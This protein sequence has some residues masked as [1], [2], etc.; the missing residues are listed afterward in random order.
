MLKSCVVASLLCVP[1]LASGQT[2]PGFYIGGAGGANFQNALSSSDG[3]TEIDTK[4][5][6]LGLGS[7]GWAFGGGAR[8]EIEG[9]Y[10]SNSITSI[11]TR[12]TNGLLEPL[13]DASG[14]SKTYAVMANATYDIPLGSLALPVQPFVGGGIGYGWID[15]GNAHGTGRATF[16]LPEN[17]T[18]TAPSSVTF[19]KEGAFAYQ[20]IVGA[21]VP[22]AVLP[23][24]EMLVEYRYFGTGGT[25]IEVDRVAIGGNTVNGVIPSASAQSR[26]KTDGNAALIGVRYAF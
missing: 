25:N 1:G 14:D 17:N 21:S 3:L 20:A 8:A 13:S 18:V 9:S 2:T 12:R 6:A 22:V 10:R 11:Q 16:H 5:G 26:F 23:G 15:L 24:L 4:T 7:V 19:G